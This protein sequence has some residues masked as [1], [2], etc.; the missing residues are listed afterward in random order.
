ML[1]SDILDGG[2]G[3]NTASYEHAIATS[4]L[5]GITASL[6]TPGSNTGH[7]LGDSYSNIQNLTGS[8]YND[9]LIGK[10]GEDNILIGGAGGDVLNGGTH[11]AN[12]D[13][14]SYAN[15]GAGVFASLFTSTF[16]SG[17]AVGDTYIGIENLTGSNY[18]DYLEGDDYANIL[19][20]G[21]SNDIL[22]GRSGNDTIYANQGH[23]SAYGD[24]NNDTI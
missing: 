23:D 8:I 21:G 12:G 15:A 18:N 2:A 6:T 17:D 14:A 1:G 4:G 16:Q 19:T 5:T 24:A 13:T 10:D 9:T 3:N 22:E 11:A 7:A 20:G